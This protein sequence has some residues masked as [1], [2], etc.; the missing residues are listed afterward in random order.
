[1][2][3]NLKVTTLQSDAIRLANGNDV[4]TTTAQGNINF[5]N[6]PEISIDTSPN[7]TT[8]GRPSVP[9]ENSF[10]YNTDTKSGE[11]YLDGAWRPMTANEGI[12][13]DNL[14]VHFYPRAQNS[15]DSVNSQMLDLSGNGNNGDMINGP[16]VHGGG[17]VFDGDDDRITIPAFSWSAY[18]LDFWI[19]NRSI[20]KPEASIGGPSSYQTLISFGGSTPGINLGGWTSGATNEVLH[21][22][23]QGPNNLTMSYTRDQVEVGYHNFVFNWNGSTYDIWVDGKKQSVYS[24]TSSYQG[25]AVLAQ[26]SD[27][28]LILGS[29]YPGTY[30]FYGTMYEFKMY[31]GQL[32]DNQVLQNFNARRKLFQK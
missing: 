14:L 3:S 10:G 13:T 31:D 28:E 11:K 7:W 30:E 24:G 15:Y 2:S 8:S 29:S 21:I 19:Y 32:S 4:I 18:C 26:Y 5:V 25:P 27:T 6:P 9:A 12:V 22:W 16:V 20:I 17:I 23:A 1:M